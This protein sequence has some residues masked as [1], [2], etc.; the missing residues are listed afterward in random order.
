M[1]N[2]SAPEH[3]HTAPAAYSTTDATA[4]VAIALLANVPLALRGAPGTG[5]TSLLRYMAHKFNWPI[6]SMTATIHDPTDLAGLPFLSTNGSLE[7]HT[8][9][10]PLEW[11]FALANEAAKHEGN[12]L[13]FFDDV[14][15]ASTAMQN[16]LLQVVQERRVGDFQLPSGVRCAAA[17]NPLTTT[18]GAHP[19]AAPLANRMIHVTWTPNAESWANGF[20]S[21]WHVELPALPEGWRHRYA[22]TRATVAAFIRERPSLLHNEPADEKGRGDPWP[23]G[24]T[25]DML[26]TALAACDAAGASATVRRILAT[27]AV[28]EEAGLEYLTWERKETLRRPEPQPSATP[29]TG[30]PSRSQPTDVS[31]RLH[32]PLQ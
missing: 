22:I 13:V 28:G 9:R 30:I 8:N 17:L 6:H 4:A 5:K 29:P 25:W 18:T 26:T 24:R 14:G 31:I 20:L 1:Q 3:G 10:A 11:A 19:L 27:G 21:G 16:S 12:G 32:R 2:A 15:Y 7:S 23:S